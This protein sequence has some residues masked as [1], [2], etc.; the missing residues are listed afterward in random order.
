MLTTI[1]R[2]EIV[3]EKPR[4]GATLAA[5]QRSFH[6]EE[7]VEWYRTHETVEAYYDIYDMLSYPAPLPTK[8]SH[9]LSP[10]HA[11]LHDFTEVLSQKLVTLLTALDVEALVLMPYLRLDIFGNQHNDYPPLV[12]AYN[13]LE[14]LL[15]TNT[16]KEAVCIP[17]KHLGEIIPA[18][19]WMIR[20]DPSLP[21]YIF[22][23]DASEQ[24]EFFICKYGNIHLTEFGE[25]KLHPQLL[26][27]LGWQL[28]EGPEIDPFTDDSIIEGRSMVM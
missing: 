21:E 2:Q 28:I 16:C 15:G 4:I 27:S 11:N 19:F 10:L 23:F 14:A 6:D 1:P 26:R 7:T 8:F 12:A 17:R 3:K 24:L 25:Q 9:I 20:C 13:K 5:L 22:L 18:L